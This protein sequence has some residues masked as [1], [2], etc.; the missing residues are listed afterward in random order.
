MIFSTAASYAIND[1]LK[2]GL[3]IANLFDK[4]GVIPY[5]A[6]GFEY[7]ATNQGAGYI[8]RE[9]FLSLDWKID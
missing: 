2:V 6:G 1:K 4:V 8:G 9:V 7:I 3:N 5:Y